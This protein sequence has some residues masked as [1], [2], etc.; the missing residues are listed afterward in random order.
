[1]VEIPEA[2]REHAAGHEEKVYQELVPGRVRGGKG[3]VQRLPVLWLRC[4]W[5]GEGVM[6]G[7]V[8]G[9]GEWVGVSVGGWGGVGQFTQEQ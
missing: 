2:E 5:L 9:G 3:I 6:Q 4:W 7:E 1:M 8:Y